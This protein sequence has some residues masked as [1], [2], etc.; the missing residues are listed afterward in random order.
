MI[1]NFNLELI[2]K[3]SDGDV[4]KL[5]DNKIIKYL[6]REK[7]NY[8]EYFILLHL[9]DKHIAQ[10]L[11]IEINKKNV[12]IVQEKANYDLRN[13]LSLR[14]KKELRFGEKIKFIMQLV[15]GVYFLNSHNLIHGDIKPENILVYND[16]LKLT[17]FYLSRDCKFNKSNRKLYT[18]NY[19]PPECNNLS[20]SLKSDIWAL[21]CTIYEIYYNQKYFLFDNKGNLYHLACNEERKKENNYINK[22]IKNMITEDIEKRIS[23][24][25]VAEYLSIRKEKTNKKNLF[26]KE[27]LTFKSDKNFINYIFFQNKENEYFKKKIETSIIKKH[28]FNLFDII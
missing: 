27:N 3:G 8:L 24:D 14:K 21:G 16:Y 25:E 4:Y 13:F 22:L 12:K 26:L 10:A 19:R 20:Y 9:Q 17:D 18:I 15:N 11:Q 1:N 2:G 5:K 23:I 6:S 7:L 28:K